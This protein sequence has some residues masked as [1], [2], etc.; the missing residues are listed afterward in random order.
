MTPL[1][2]QEWTIQN[3]FYDDIYQ[4]PDDENIKQQDIDLKADN[5]FSEFEKESLQAG[6]QES[7]DGHSESQIST[8][9]EI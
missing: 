9:D 5:E 4:D 6:T 8:R 1:G 7:S 2:L 3:D